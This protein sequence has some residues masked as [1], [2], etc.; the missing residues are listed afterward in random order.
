MISI[1]ILRGE[2][3]KEIRQYLRRKFKLTK[4]G[5][6]DIFFSRFRSERSRLSFKFSFSLLSAH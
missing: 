6:N 4:K 3:K 1:D 2:T 5:E